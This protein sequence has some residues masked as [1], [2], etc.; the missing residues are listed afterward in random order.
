[1]VLF[2]VV[3][4]LLFVQVVKFHLLNMALLL[5]QWQTQITPAITLLKLIVIMVIQ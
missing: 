4:L 3:V 5:Y 2:V 1:M